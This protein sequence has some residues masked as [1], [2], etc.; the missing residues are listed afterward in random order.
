MSWLHIYTFKE[1]SYFL[2]IT[3]TVQCGPSKREQRETTTKQRIIGQRPQTV[4]VFDKQ[5]GL[6]ISSMLPSIWDMG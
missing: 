5:G 3:I 6:S 2:I 1:R 4:A